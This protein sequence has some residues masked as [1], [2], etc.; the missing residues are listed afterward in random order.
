[1]SGTAGALT[2]PNVNEFAFY[3]Q[4]TWRTNDR[5]TLYYGV[6]YDLFSYA[7]PPV[8]NPD[9]GLAAAGIDTS[10]INKDT[11]NWSGRFGFAYKL[12]A[13]GR[14]AVRGGY[15][16]YYGRTPSI[17]TG[18]S[19]SQ[20]G[21]QVQTYTIAPGPG[22]PTYPT[23]LSAPPT[24]SRTINLY[25]FAP[26]Y[27]QPLTHQWSF[28]LELEP[29]RN[30]AI[31]VGYLGVRGEHLTRTRDINLFP[32]LLTQ[33]SFADGTP[34]SFLRYPN[35]RPNPN[36]GRISLFDSGASSIYHGGFIQ[37]SKRFSN[38]FQLQTSYTFSKVIDTV[39]DFTSVVPGGGDDAKVPQYTTLP[40]LDRGL[41][42]SDARHRFV[43]SSV[44]EIDYARSIQNAVLRNILRGYQLSLIA[45]LQSGRFYSATVGGNADVANDGN[46]RNDRSPYVGRNTIEAPGYAT[47]DMRFSRDI[48]VWKER[49]KLKIIFE[50]F[51]LANRPNFGNINPSVTAITTTQYNFNSTT[52]VFS[53]NPTFRQPLDT[54]DPRI[55]QLAAKFTF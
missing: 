13:D 37:L 17:L 46:S 9:A 15:G 19:M 45:N 2:Q 42:N 31:T 18:T 5:L 1:G 49:A 16:M 30:Y 40:G 38:S 12:R 25:A 29:V 14:V 4:D 39:P 55:L 24:A 35:T 53:L 41:G 21:I 6:R 54:F 43:L 52:R 28:N 44:W 34:V 8:K 47:F 22:F 50:A 20:N 51:N 3:A 36:F 27:L 32:P 23:I 10:R 7:Q 11:N 48:H 26:D 33:G